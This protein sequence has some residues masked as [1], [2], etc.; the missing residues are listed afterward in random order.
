MKKE[1]ELEIKKA[2]EELTE[3]DLEKVTGGSYTC[4]GEEGKDIKEKIVESGAGT[5]STH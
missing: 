1:N 4:Q 3:Q 5:C 2:P